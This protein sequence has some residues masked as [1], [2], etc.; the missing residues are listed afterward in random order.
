MPDDDDDDKAI[1]SD[2]SDRKSKMSFSYWGADK[3][4]LQK[5]LPKA[6][7]R[8]SGLANG[9]SSSGPRRSAN[10]AS[11]GRESS[12]NAKFGTRLVVDPASASGT[13]PRPASRRTQPTPAARRPAAQ[14]EDG[15]VVRA[16]VTRPAWGA[17]ATTGA[18]RATAATPQPAGAKRPR[19]TSQ[20]SAAVR[21]TSTSTTATKPVMA[22]PAP[23]EDSGVGLYRQIMSKDPSLKEI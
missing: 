6:A 10:Q 4:T 16:T 9:S 3:V 22:S 15:H 20:P 21:A 14:S 8:P 1:D 19:N 2:D 18:P 5:P 11:Y 17:G 7:G 13:G 23:S 12:A